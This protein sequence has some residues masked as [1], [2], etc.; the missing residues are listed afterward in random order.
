M[1]PTVLRYY[2]EIDGTIPVLEWLLELRGANARAFAKCVAKIRRLAA[3]GYELRRPDADY[4]RDGIY[5]LRIRDGSVNYRILYFFHG[6]NVAILGH[7]LTKEDRVP[8]A[9]INRAVGRKRLVERSPARHVEMET[10]ING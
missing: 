7:A 4:L 5:E 3:A 6:E 8:P 9:E 2:R 10:D 1:P